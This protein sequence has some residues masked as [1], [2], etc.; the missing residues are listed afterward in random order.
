MTF[1][2]QPNPGTTITISILILG[3]IIFISLIIHPSIQASAFYNLWKLFFR[4]FCFSFCFFSKFRWILWSFCSCACF[5]RA[6]VPRFYSVIFYG[7]HGSIFAPLRRF[8][9]L[10]SI[11]TSSEICWLFSIWV[12]VCV[13]FL[14]FKQKSS[15]VIIF[16]LLYFF[17]FQS[18]SESTLFVAVGSRG[19]F[20]MDRR[21]RRRNNICSI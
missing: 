3:L 21:L 11:C 20:C 6:I 16:H 5:K 17:E 14:Q 7:F 19:S 1:P 15:L 18:S 13:F 10:S 4:R 2:K 12:C 9:S 8:P